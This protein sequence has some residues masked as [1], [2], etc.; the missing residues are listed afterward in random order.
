MELYLIIIVK[1]LY[2]ILATKSSTTCSSN[3]DKCNDNTCFKCSGDFALL[4]GVC[5][6]LTGSA[7]Y[8]YLSPP[9]IG[10]ANLTFNAITGISSGT[11]MQGSFSYWI[12]LIGFKYGTSSPYDVFIFGNTLKNTY[13]GTN[14]RLAN[15]TTNFFTGS[16]VAYGSFVH[17][18]VSYFYD[19]SN[20]T[21]PAMLDFSINYSIQTFSSG[22]IT[23]LNINNTQIPATVIAIFAKLYV[24]NTYIYQVHGFMVNSSNSGLN[25]APTLKKLIDGSTTVAGCID[26]ADLNS[27]TVAG[28]GLKCVS[29]SDTQFDTSLWCTTKSRYSGGTCTSKLFI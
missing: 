28:L 3:C 19:T 25:P 23:G 16:A 12:K 6:A 20:T 5:A 7:K 17:V 11:I 15:G 27:Q 14:L 13:N 29:A 21:F 10:T 24:Y 1:Y 9:S 26:N 2:N 4:N 22:T 18:G 8:Y